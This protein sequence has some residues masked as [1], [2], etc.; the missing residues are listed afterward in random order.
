MNE[1]SDEMARDILREKEQEIT[2]TNEVKEDS[3]ITRNEDGKVI[4][5]GKI[6][7]QPRMSAEVSPEHIN[8]MPENG[9]K[10]LP[11][12]NLPSRGMFYPDGIVISIKAASVREIRHFSTIDEGDYIDGDDKLNHILESCCMVRIPGKM[13]ANWKDIQDMDRFYIIYCI[14]EF[15]FKNGE[16]KLTMSASC[17]HCGNTDQV[18]LTKNNI[19]FFHIDERLM[20]YYD[21]Q[22]K[23]F[24]I[25]MKDNEDGTP[26]KPFPV[27]MPTLGIGTFI[28]QYVSTK[29]N[30]QQYYDK[31]FIRMAPFMFKDWRTLNE[32]NYND[33]NTDTLTYG[34]KKLSV[35]SGIIDIMLKSINT[36]ITH[37]CTSCG[38]EVTVPI[39]FQGGF[40]SLFMYTEIF[41]ELA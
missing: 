18:E 3:N 21:P 39:N 28:R 25:R 19:A 17:N 24:M 37:R 32:V 20:K 38:S 22:N 36:D 31:T 23:C 1:I 12:E 33:A 5:L 16:N 40:K 14:R 35:V 15:T 26:N 34:H 41:D 11:I 29:I 10:N 6:P 7:T 8:K 9:W 13:D 2:K 30:N 4:S 27:Y